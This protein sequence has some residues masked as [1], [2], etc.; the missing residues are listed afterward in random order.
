VGVSAVLL[1][2]IEGAK[3]L[4]HTELR[5]EEPARLARDTSK[6]NLAPHDSRQHARMIVFLGRSVRMGF[7]MTLSLLVFIGC[8]VASVVVEQTTDTNP[9]IKALSLL[10]MFGNMGL[11]GALFQILLYLE[12]SFS[13]R[14]LLSKSWIPTASKRGSKMDDTILAS[15]RAS[16]QDAGVGALVPH[17][18]GEARLPAAEAQVQLDQHDGHAGNES[19]ML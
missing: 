6:T 7:Y 4:G 15:K 11:L 2:E 19:E 8:A 5:V 12:P 18:G 9:D 17:A 1:Q 16:K 13:R 10:N 3:A 14:S